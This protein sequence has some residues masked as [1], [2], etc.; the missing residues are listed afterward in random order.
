MAEVSL[1]EKVLVI[2]TI[3]PLCVYECECVD[4]SIFGYSCCFVR[5]EI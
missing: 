4:S 2:H 3:P 1:T 5:F